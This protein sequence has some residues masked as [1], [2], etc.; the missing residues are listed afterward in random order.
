MDISTPLPDKFTVAGREVEIRALTMGSL[1]KIV[2]VL[3]AG[4]LQGMPIDADLVTF[5]EVM[6]EECIQIVCLATDITREE[7]DKVEVS[8]F[9]ILLSAVLEK[10][11]DFF[12][13]RLGR[14]LQ[15]LLVRIT[16]IAV[17]AG[18]MP[19]NSLSLM[20]TGLLKSMTTPTGNSLDS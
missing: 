3:D 4:K 7:I 11:K 2:K 5:L 18:S 10:N 6:P 12:V 20:D 1:M 8:D 15:I 16:E 17:L 13:K 14:S 19:S 9:V